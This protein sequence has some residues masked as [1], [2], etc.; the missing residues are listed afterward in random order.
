MFYRKKNNN[1]TKGTEKSLKYLFR[2]IIF[3]SKGSEPT[4]TQ[5]NTFFQYNLSWNNSV[6][7][8]MSSNSFYQLNLKPLMHVH[9]VPLLAIRIRL[10]KLW[11]G[12]WTWN[13]IHL[14][15]LVNPINFHMSTTFVPVEALGQINEIAHIRILRSVTEQDIG[16]KD[17]DYKHNHDYIKEHSLY[18]LI[19]LREVNFNACQCILFSW[20]LQPSFLW[21]LTLEDQ[22]LQNSWWSTV[23]QSAMRFSHKPPNNKQK[24]DKSQIYQK[25][26]C[27]CICSHSLLSMCF[28][29]FEAFVNLDSFHLLALF[30]N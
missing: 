24:F 29:N 14:T 28:T 25:I 27:M 23:H 17:T 19:H 1:P 13:D 11:S 5:S 30:P 22:I 8:P 15:S 20:Q 3:W 26:L 18:L 21:S 6:S 2:W 10:L 4:S 16:F 12:S 7:S 9:P